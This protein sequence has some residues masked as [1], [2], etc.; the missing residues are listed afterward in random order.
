MEVPA[1]NDP[2]PP[3]FSTFTLWQKRYIVFLATFA[4]VFSPM[5]SFIFYPAINSIAHGLS[6]G[7]GLVNLSI[8]SYMVVS[9]IVPALLGDVAD[10]LGR[11]PVYIF[12]LGIY[13]IANV[14]LALQNSFPA[15]LVLRMLQSAGSSGA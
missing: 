8:T 2:T 7:V 3:P 6:V 13:F 5:S 10:R 12:A 15:L 14:G 9:A 11:R 4:A 1:T